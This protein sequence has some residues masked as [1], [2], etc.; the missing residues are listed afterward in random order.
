[1][2]KL[3]FIILMLLSHNVQ[4]ACD[5]FRGAYSDTEL[6]SMVYA[7]C[8][9]SVPSTLPFRNIDGIPQCAYVENADGC[10]VRFKKTYK[11]KDTTS[12]IDGDQVYGTYVNLDDLYGPLSAE[13]E[14]SVESY[15]SEIGVTKEEYIYIF[16]WGAGAVLTFWVC[17]FFISAAIRIVKMI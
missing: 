6:R 1:M 10:L 9:A 5:F 11:L 7:A 8:G 13:L 15:F 4:S 16:W 2:F 12:F 3:F 14:R 17:G